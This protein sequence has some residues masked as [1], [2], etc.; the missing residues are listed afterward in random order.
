MIKITRTPT[1]AEGGITEEEKEKMDAISKKWIDR[2]YYTGKIDREKITDAINRLYEA[3]GLEKPIV[4]IVPSPLVMALAGGIASAYWKTVNETRD[5]TWKA[6]YN[7]TWNVT[8]DSTDNETYNSTITATWNATRKVTDIETDDQTRDATWIE[9]RDATWNAGWN[10]IYSATSD[11]TNKTTDTSTRAA[12]DNEIDNSTDISTYSVTSDV[13]YYVADDAT[14]DSTDNATR[15]ATDNK[16]NNSTDNWYKE[17]CQH[18]LGNNYK[19]AMEEARNWRNHS[20]G[21]NMW[22]GMC[23][24]YEAVRDVLKL[25][26]LDIWDK[27]QAWEDSAYH[28]G[29]R[30]MHEKFCLVCEFPEEIHINDKNEA[31]NTEGASH[32]WSDGFEIYTMNGV[33]VPE[34]LAKTPATN[35]NMK[36]YDSIKNADVKA[37]FILKCGADRFVDRANIVDTYDKYKYPWWKESEYKLIDMSPLIDELGYAPYLYMKNQTKEI[38]HVEPV[39][40]GCKNLIDAWISRYG[41]H[42]NEVEI[43]WVS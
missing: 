33:V 21:G 12:T 4:I 30:Y 19:I 23:S 28:G 10:V 9:T 20:Q 13:A 3:A 18:F 39:G 16:I 29:Y 7:K 24:Y 17:M 14:S 34:W 27:Y 35:L 2:A 25:T 41:V 42:P 22:A 8:S 11:S 26:G 31:H 36:Q 1:R 43:E 40:V 32:R 37:Q 15:D 5:L 6:T 38:Y